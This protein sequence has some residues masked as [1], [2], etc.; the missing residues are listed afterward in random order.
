M[1]EVIDEIEVPVEIV[2]G[3]KV[4]KNPLGDGLDP[5]IDQGIE[6]E[7]VDILQRVVQDHDLDP[8]LENNQNPLRKHHRL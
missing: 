7:G 2:I 5:E 4:T 1:I 3:K 6:L 8:D